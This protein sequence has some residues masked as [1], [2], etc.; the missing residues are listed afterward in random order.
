[1]LP[2]GARLKRAVASRRCPE[3]RMERPPTQAQSPEPRACIRAGRRRP[4][5]EGRVCRRSR[6]V[7]QR[8][9]RGAERHH[10]RRRGVWHRD[11][12]VRLRRP[13]MLC[14]LD[15]PP[16]AC[17][18][19]LPQRH[20]KGAHD[21]RCGRRLHIRVPSGQHA[22]RGR[23]VRARISRH[24]ERHS[25]GRPHG[26]QLPLRRHQRVRSELRR[27]HRIEQSERLPEGH[28]L[29]KMRLRTQCVFGALHSPA[30]PR[31]DFEPRVHRGARL[32]DEGERRG[33]N[34][35]F[36]VASRQSCFRQCRV[37]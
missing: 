8:R 36:R 9:R 26:A 16:R 12:Q 1:M 10:T 13:Q 2:E 4:R 25:C 22:N 29:R 30:R 14:V 37:L 27:R 34:R 19:G 35:D 32:R 6:H 28:R 17:A 11:E 3:Q 31:C 33:R 20:C 18:Q 7:A 21:L 15:A 23:H 24:D 5:N